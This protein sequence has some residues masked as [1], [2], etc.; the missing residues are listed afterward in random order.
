M[1]KLIHY[2]F[3]CLLHK[4]LHEHANVAEYD[5]NHILLYHFA[6]NW[7]FLQHFDIFINFLFLIYNL[8]ALLNP[9]IQVIALITQL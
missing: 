6:Y 2:L 3:G 4:K 7:Q 8:L 1:I 9:L 5:R